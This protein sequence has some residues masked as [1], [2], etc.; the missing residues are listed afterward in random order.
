MKQRSL[1]DFDI[2]VR[3]SGVGLI[4]LAALCLSLLPAD[5]GN[6]D[7]QP[8]AFDVCTA[9]LAVCSGCVGAALVFEGRR[10]FDPVSDPRARRDVHRGEVR[11]KR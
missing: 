7:A 5:R 10:L 9:L 1:Q 2:K 3:I 8:S 6:P 4:L 11:A